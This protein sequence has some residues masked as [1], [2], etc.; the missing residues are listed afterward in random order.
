MGET[1]EGHGCRELR[2]RRGGLFVLKKKELSG[3]EEH[4]QGPFFLLRKTPPGNAEGH[5]FEYSSTKNREHNHPT[6]EENEWRGLEPSD[7]NQNAT[8]AHLNQKAVHKS[9]APK[10]EWSFPTFM[11]RV[12]QWETPLGTWKCL[13]ACLMHGQTSSLTKTK[14]THACPK[15]GKSSTFRKPFVEERKEVFRWR[16]K[17]T[18]VVLESTIPG[19]LVSAFLSL[20]ETRIWNIVSL[21]KG[22]ELSSKG[23]QEKRRPRGSG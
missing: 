5:C 6:I 14:T 1:W 7:L 22:T 18:K 9:G 3:R 19:H 8:H 16:K 20:G 23:D 13:H 4:R 2:C 17:G 21:P 15:E 11:A 12:S 10:R